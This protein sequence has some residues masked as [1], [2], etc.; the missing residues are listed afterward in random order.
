MEV[1]VIESETFQQIMQRLENIESHVLRSNDIYK[2][3]NE[4]Q[5]ELTSREMME[6]LKV[7]ESTLYRWRQ[8]RLVPFRYTDT[9]SIRFP[10]D[11]V[12]HAVYTGNLTVRSIEK[13]ELLA[14]LTQ[15]KDQ[16]I[17][18]SIAAKITT[19]DR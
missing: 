16:L 8:D 7:S 2:Q 3:V 13:Q 19:H 15:F 4:G 17:K 12:Y 6:T 14:Y 10:F 18:K 1:I 11:A 9:G 5:I